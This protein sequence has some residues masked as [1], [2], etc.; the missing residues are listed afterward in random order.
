MNAFLN[1]MIVQQRSRHAGEQ[2]GFLSEV[3]A[4]RRSLRD[5]NPLIPLKAAAGQGNPR[6][7]RAPEVEPALGSAR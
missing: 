7:E 5:P 3:P 6:A 4:G 2:A 1:Y